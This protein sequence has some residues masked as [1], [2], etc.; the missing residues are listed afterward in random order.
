MMVL[1]SRRAF[2][3]VSRRGFHSPFHGL[4]SE[5]HSVLGALVY[6][7]RHEAVGVRV[8]FDSPL[9]VDPGGGR[10]WWSS[11][12]ER[13]IMYLQPRAAGRFDELRLDS[14]VRKIGRFGGFSD[15]VQ[16]STPYL[17]PMTYGVSRT[18]LHRLLE[19][20]IH[21]RPEI[22]EAAAS[23]IARGFD[24]CAYVIGVHYR[25]TDA[26]YGL[27]GHLTHYRTTPVPYRAYADE[28]RH[29]V[30]AAGSPRYQVFVATDEIEFLYF[31]ESPRVP[32][33]SNGVHLDRRLP[34][35]N[36]Q[37][38]KSAIVDCLLLAASSYLV[39]GRSN[40]SDAAL[41]FNPRLSY[42]FYPDVAV[43]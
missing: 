6:A 23:V 9:Y 25:G 12:F 36:Y 31:E 2:P 37:K 22:Q 21:V 1:P 18:A 30:G 43:P 4:F 10:N 41:M 19:S 24:P 5:F 42:S 3:T 28:V 11:F 39:K 17:Y 34:V 13:D 26:T 33:G 20:H 38:G 35:S 27:S 32:A 16:G 14:L 40:L 7:E 15:V 29:V 8:D